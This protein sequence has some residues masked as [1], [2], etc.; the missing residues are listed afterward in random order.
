MNTIIQKIIKYRRVISLFLKHPERKFTPLELSKITKVPYAN[1]WRLVQGLKQKKIILVEHI[2][3]YNVCMLNTKFPKISALK[4][5]FSSI[6]SLEP[7]ARQKTNAC[8]ISKTM[9]EGDHEKV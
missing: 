9:K 3:A 6:N 4:K 5:L 1:V 2:G 7:Q 8:H